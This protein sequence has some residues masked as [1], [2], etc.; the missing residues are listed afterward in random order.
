MT[1]AIGN[2]KLSHN[3]QVISIFDFCLVNTLKMK[4]N[5]V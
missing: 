3:V 4:N 5:R 1:G 2:S